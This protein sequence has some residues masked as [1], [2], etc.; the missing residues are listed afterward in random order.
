MPS[1]AQIHHT[2]K[3]LAIMLSLLA[4]FSG[5]ARGQ[6][7]FYTDD[8]D[9]TPKGHLHFEFS[10]EFD[11]L[12]RSSYPNLKQNTADFELDFGVYD[13][14]EIG[15]EAPLLTIFNTPGTIPR[16]ASGIGDTN[17]SVKYDFRSE[18]E[19]SRIP[20]MAI[21]FNMELP[22]GNSKR[23]LGSGLADYY[24]NSVL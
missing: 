2:V 15:I 7:P 20:A 22:T 1:R 5:N 12:Q 16:T 18:R 24:L 11:L 9:V 21:T 10:N 17:V 6:Q 13:R 23:Q 3:T 8:T 14:L 4:L 19:S